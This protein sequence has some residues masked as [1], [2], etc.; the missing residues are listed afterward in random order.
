MTNDEILKL[1]RQHYE[2]L[3]FAHAL[4][5]KM[6]QQEEQKQ[7]Q[8]LFDD[9]RGGFPYKSCPPCNHNCEQGRRCPARQA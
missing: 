7:E 3:G 9:W 1:W 5:E 4:M 8:P 2:V 6:K